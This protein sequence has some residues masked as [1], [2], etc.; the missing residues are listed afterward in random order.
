MLENQTEGTNGQ[1]CSSRCQL[2]LQLDY[3]IHALDL[4]RHLQ[5]HQSTPT[6]E[7]SATMGKQHPLLASEAGPGCSLHLTRHLRLRLHQLLPWWSQKGRES[8]RLL[9]S[10]RSGLVHRQ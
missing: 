10:L 9:H 6:A 5:R 4:L 1:V 3:P 7:R 2:Q 8:Q